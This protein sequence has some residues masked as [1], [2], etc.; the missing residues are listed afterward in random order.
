MSSSNNQTPA[1]TSRTPP[2]CGL[3]GKS[4]PVKEPCAIP[5]HLCGQ[6]HYAE[7]YGDG[8]CPQLLPTVRD[9]RHVPD[10][11]C[12]RCE[13]YSDVGDQMGEKEEKE[14]TSVIEEEGAVWESKPDE[15]ETMVTV[16]S[17]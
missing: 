8:I 6:V 1:K 5:C 12:D 3:C 16:S 11:E 7:V 17:R 2:P 15:L 14:E 4:H 13:Y 10:Y 9:L